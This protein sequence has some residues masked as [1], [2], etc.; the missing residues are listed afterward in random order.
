MVAVLKICYILL[1]MTDPPRFG[2]IDALRGY[3]ILM[4][5]AVH[6][7]QVTPELPKWLDLLAVQG[8][9]GVQLF[10]LVSALTLC[11]SWFARQQS[12]QAFYVRRI[13]RIAP[14]FWLAIAFWYSNAS[15]SSVNLLLSATMLHA[16][17][18]SAINLIVPG[19]WSIGVEALFYLMF[20][21]VVPKLARASWTANALAFFA[22]V[23]IGVLA[24]RMGP[25][26]VGRFFL[27]P[28][29]ELAVYFFLWLPRQL[30]CFL[31]GIMVF[32]ALSRPIAMPHSSALLT[33][34]CTAV[35]FIATALFVRVPY[36]E[37]TIYGIIF[38]VMAFSFS[39]LRSHI[40][41]NR[42]ICW[43]GS[44][45][46]SAYFIHFGLISYRVSV[47]FSTGYPA[48]DFALTFALLAALTIGIATISY[49]L[50]ERPFIRLGEAVLSGPLR[51]KSPVEYRAG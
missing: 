42:A 31:L 13:F 30:P 49:L 5:I 3:A 7:S 17:S 34:S 28:G 18:P 19:G 35:A 10:F 15:H 46:Y 47:I 48:L 22:A 12:A 32:K 51:A 37:Q 39:H 20:P 16:L 43:I 50:I 27:L 33:I 21:F 25:N 36:T 45:S 40:F 41:I 24:S 2:Y 11:M 23:V 44:V 6:T 14:M 9:R 4:V 38:A 29:E 8:A 26:I 1:V